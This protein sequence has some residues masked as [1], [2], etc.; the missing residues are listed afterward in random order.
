M[1]I[2]GNILKSIEL[3]QSICISIGECWSYKQILQENM[4]KLKE[5]MDKLISREKDIKKELENVEYQFQKE[6]KAEVE[7]WLK[8]VESKRGEVDEIEHVAKKRRYFSRP[9]FLRKIENITKEVN[10]VFDRGIFPN[11]VVNDTYLDKGLALPSAKLVG[12]AT[13]KRNL[14]KIWEILVKEDIRSVG[15]YGMGGVGKTTIVTHIHNRLLE[16]SR[17]FGSI[18]WVTVSQESS[19]HI[20]QNKIALKL[21]VDFKGDE[22]EI[23]RAAMLLE[24]LN[25]R[26][27]FVFILDDMWESYSIEGVGIP[28]NEGSK[29]KLIITSRSSEVCQQMC[30]K[31][32]KVEPLST[33][34]AW[35]LFKEKLGSHTVLIDLEVERIAK[36]IA[37][38]CAGL[39]LAIITIARSLIG[40]CDIYEWNNALDE[41]KQHAP[42]ITQN[43]KDVYKRLKFSYDRLKNEKM[44][45][46]FLYCALFPEDHDIPRVELIRYWICEGLIDEM[47]TRQQE[48]NRGHSRLNE[49]INVCLLQSS[50]SH[51]HNCVKMHDVIRDMALDI[52]RSDKHMFMVKAGAQLEEL[53]NNRNWQGSLERISLMRNFLGRGAEDFTSPMCPLLFTLLLNDNERLTKMSNIFFA[54]MPS[55]TVLDL[56][57]TGIERVPDSLS[58]LTNL[59]ALL[60]KTCPKLKYV[61]SLAQLKKLRE[62]DLQKSEK[63][64]ALMGIE[65]LCD[66]KFLDLCGMSIKWMFPQTERGGKEVLPKLRQ[67]QCIGVG[68][69]DMQVDQLSVLTKLESIKLWGLDPLKFNNYVKSEAWKKLKR[70]FL[71]LSV[72][73]LQLPEIL[74]G[75]QLCIDYRGVRNS[76]EIGELSLMLPSNVQEL[77]LR[78]CNDFCSLLDFSSSLKNAEDLERCKI[79]SCQGMH[80]LWADNCCIATTDSN[81]MPLFLP[82]LETLVLRDLQN[83]KALLKLQ[84]GAVGRGG[85]EQSL[86][87]VSSGSFSNLKLLAI[88]ECHNVKYIFPFRFAQKH[89]QNLEIMFV[90]DCKNIENIISA[91]DRDEEEEGVHQERSKN[92]MFMFPKL[93][94]LWLGYLPK[95]Q[96]LI[97]GNK[98]SMVSDYLQE[99]LIY[100]CPN[101]KSLP[102][103]I[104]MH[105]NDIGTVSSVLPPPT[106]IKRIIRVKRNQFDAMEAYKANAELMDLQPLLHDRP[107]NTDIQKRMVE[108]KNEASRLREANRMLLAQI[109]K[110]K[111]LKECDK[112]P[113]GFLACFF[114]RSWN[115]VGKEFT[116]AIREFLSTGKLLKRINHTIIALIPKSSHALTINDFGPI[117]CC[118][119]M[120]KVIAKIIATRIKPCLEEIVKPAQSTFVKHRSMVGNIYL[121]QEL[122]RRNSLA[123]PLRTTESRASD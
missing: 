74:F 122:E 78:G 117:S 81:I 104:S 109:A 64:G 98:G 111:Y 48:Y 54:S 22:A 90:H 5:N 29:G 82:R 41:L 30:Q 108:K 31:I 47:D 33:K 119:V 120:H 101:L 27:K 91:V 14:E 87:P 99:I 61:P 68:G 62:L 10:G 70:Y 3:V 121:V 6:P 9:K 2:W 76:S 15:V 12:E 118:N 46:C 24:A 77:I 83:L 4:K 102:I 28:I 7:N 49:L 113:D 43:V 107:S 105:D 123:T 86:S 116:N 75:R 69:K 57:S 13:A 18:F 95:L 96:G 26:K 51:P 112:S 42:D 39:P 45:Q 44:Q 40:V 84:E 79:E 73:V 115:T 106:T 71:C 11:G 35:S 25:A 88:L 80:Y 52:A 36:S 92:S 56:S 1:D 38:E 16:N 8:S 66:L 97:C 17:V 37:K 53:P 65:E 19:V 103:S 85:L 32:I 94:E 60:L 93:Q 63:C 20:L 100:G 23:T 50:V 21:N 55:L 72:D 34:E 110:G 114:K 89:L 59:R 67:L 58:S